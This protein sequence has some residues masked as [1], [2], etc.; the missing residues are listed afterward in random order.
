MSQAP[1]P[2]LTRNKAKAMPVDCTV[3]EKFGWRQNLAQIERSRTT[4]QSLLPDIAVDSWIEARLANCRLR[5]TPVP[6][7]SMERWT[8]DPVSGNISHDTGRFF[9]FKGVE[10]RHRTPSG[11]LE[12]DQPII[13]QPEIGILGIIAKMIGGVLHFCLQAKEEPGN[14]NSV[15]LSPT[16]QATF[17]NYT[18]AHGG[19]APP[20]VEYFLSPPPD[21]LLFGKLQ[22]EDGGR[23]LFKSNRNM[24][25]RV[26]DDDL[27]VLPDGFIWLTLRQIVLL[28]KRDNL[29]HATTRS[30]LSSLLLPDA[31]SRGK[32]LP[33]CS[34]VS[35]AETIQWL[36]DRKAA[37]HMLVTRKGL[38]DLREWTHGDEGEFCHQEGRFFKV[39]GISVAAADREVQ[40][41]C[42]PIL[43]NQQPGVV[44]MLLKVEQGQRFFLVQA[45][46]EAG[47]RTVVQLGPTAQFSTHN[48]LNNPRLHKPFLFNEFSSPA[49]FPLLAESMQAEEGARFFRETNCHRVLMLPEGEK[50]DLPEDFRW[51]P[52]EE[53]RFFLNLGECV[54][55]CARSI[56][57]CLI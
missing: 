19:A 32:A 7:D 34:G 25:V 3:A 47:N 28:M 37:N 44:G 23:F 12:W 4:E 35:L 10:V 16:V 18:R 2:P 57:A 54:N 20:F 52:E 41:W 15:Q 27:A 51:L 13:E 40:G 11:E 8:V 48:Y 55:S 9:S 46:A 38:N 33:E 21:S 45:K 56:I 17:S 22:T 5:V 31:S 30:V 49:R 1:L 39:M 36:D 43:A 50:I 24:I 26:G 42:Q 29:V 53:I 6:L 14:I